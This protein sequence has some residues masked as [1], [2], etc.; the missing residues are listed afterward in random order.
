MSKEVQTVMVEV[1]RL[2]KMT[3]EENN[4]EEDLMLRTD[5]MVCEENRK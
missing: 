2:I 5:L 1:D 4:V 3:M